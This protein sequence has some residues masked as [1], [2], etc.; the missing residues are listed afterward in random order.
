MLRR[1]AFTLIELLVVIAIIAVLIGLLLPAVQKVR[2]AAARLKCQNN[3]KQLGVA[4]H[5]HESALQVF[6]QGR[7]AYPKVVSAPARLLAYVEQ[8]SL[9]SLIDPDG[10][11]AVGTQNDT[12]GKNRVALLG[13]PSDPTGGVV[14]GSAYF[15]TNYVACNGLGVSV[16]A[17]GATTAHLK[18]GEGNGA[19]AQTPCR[20]GDITDGLSNTAA[21]SESLVGNGV[22]ISGVPTD[23]QTAK[24]A[25]LEV[26]GGGD[27]TPALCDA[28]T[29]TWNARRSEQWINGH[30]G[31][32]LYNHYYTP[33]QAGKWDCGNASHNKG[34]TA[35]RSA[36]TGGVN[37]LLCDGSAKFV[38]DGVDATTWRGLATRAGGEVLGDF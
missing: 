25:V 36:H 3:L 16:D 29:G 15:G 6:P 13:C 26:A 28:G 9:Q 12:A 23:P 17:T 37:L 19:F 32:T 10:T 4:L 8:A 24:L 20:V 35:A 22:T 2:E 33:N 14:P 11:L 21:F 27:P 38:R 18:I 30:Y 7:N 34:L 5:N 31:N 1:S